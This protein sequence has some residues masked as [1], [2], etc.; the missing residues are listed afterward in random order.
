MVLAQ[1]R[2]VDNTLTMANKVLSNWQKG[3]VQRINIR[4]ADCLFSLSNI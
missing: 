1:E 3:I 4:N 2:T